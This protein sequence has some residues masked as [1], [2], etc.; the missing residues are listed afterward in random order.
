MSRARAGS[1]SGSGA[2]EWVLSGRAPLSALRLSA[3]LRVESGLPRS[4]L[5]PESDVSTD[6]IYAGR[7]TYRSGMTAEEMAR[8]IFENLDGAETGCVEPFIRAGD[9]LLAGR[10]FGR[11]SSREQ[12]ATALKHRGIAAVVAVSVNATYLRNAINNGLLVLECPALEGVLEEIAALSAEARARG[13]IGH[14][15]LGPAVAL[16]AER[17]TLT[18]GEGAV[19][20]R[21]MPLAP[22]MRELLEAGGVEQWAVKRRDRRECGGPRGTQRGEKGESEERK[23]HSEHAGIAA[24]DCVRGS[25]P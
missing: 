9:V 24:R 23:A 17:G 21:V 6:A 4:I 14:A 8:V 10:N 11:G 13:E 7:H 18:L 19:V 2:S 1:A 22:F 15:R 5:V 16:D 25:T 3:A 20:L 12:A